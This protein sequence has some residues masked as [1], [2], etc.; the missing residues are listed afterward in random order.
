MME[1]FHQ[2]H[3]LQPGWL[4]ALLALPVCL[5]LGLRRDASRRELSKLAD[6]ALLPYLVTGQGR[7]THTPAWLFSLG[8]LL[9]TLALAG[10]TWSRIAEPMYTNRAAQ[11]VAIS[12][13]Q[14]MQ[15]TDIQPSRMQRARY[16]ARDLLAANRDGLNA[17]IG[18]AGQS[19]VVAPLTSDAHSLDD[20]LNAMGPDTMPVDGD[21]AAQAIQQ[22]VE[23]IRHA[24]LNNGS[25]VLITDDAD[26]AAQAAARAASLSGV[27]VSVLGVGTPQGA[28][29]PQGDTG[30]A[31]DE[32]GNMIVARR[33]DHD[34]SN[35]AQAGGGRYAVMSEDSSDITVLHAELQPSQHATLAEGQAGDV[36]QDRG[37][38]LLLP[39]LLVAAMTFRRGW[40][41]LLPLVL[42]PCWPTHAYASGWQDWW[43]RPDQQ[44]ASALQQGNAAKAQQLAQDPA[45]RGVAAY[46]AKDYNGA[47]QALEQAKGP[48]AA[49][50]LGN[51]LAKLGKYPGAIKAYDRALQLNPA[52]DD[53][54]VNRNAVEEAM[55]KQQQQNSPSQQQQKSGNGQSDQSQQKDQSGQSPGQNQSDQNQ[56]QQ[57]GQS[58]QQ[59]NGAQQDAKNQ[60]KPDQSGQ[61]QNG[62]QQSNG[63]QDAQARSEQQDAKSQQE[64]RDHDSQNSASQNPAPAS[65]SEQ[66]Q[67]EQAQQALRQ[68]MNH[69]LA[70]AQKKGDKKPVTHELGAID[71]DDPLSKLPD[72]VRR[73][74]ERVPDDPGALL[75]RKFE[76]EYRKR[77]GAQPVDGDVQ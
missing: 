4:F 61:Q 25:I 22:G 42:L 70:Q 39:L 5:W 19:F 74:L 53:A 66:V 27:H 77:I 10:P 45:W 7:R 26:N 32:Q 59:Q 1:A 36:W 43:Q 31:H 60:A 56:A 68:Q 69:A 57:G 44:A 73:N 3:F 16:K 24:K 37:P 41:M 46:R 34:L 51:A 49:Y 38:W 50:N 65:S 64:Q 33:D 75:R 72:D 15:A 58:S 40:V 20:L 35:L 52:N 47:V 30:F 9:C 2:F 8:W 48:D 14:H 18:Y 54:R 21:N 55:R 29:V 6:E 17:L 13:S 63:T 23:L 28:P 76:L 71:S 12:L 11:I 67:T 62:Q